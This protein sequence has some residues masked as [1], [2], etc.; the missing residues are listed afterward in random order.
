MDEDA[1]RQ[2]IEQRRVAWNAQDTK[3]YASLLTSDADIVSATGRAA[4][5]REEIIRLYVEQMSGPYRGAK[6]ASTVVTR[7]R[8]VRPDV[9]LVDTEFEMEGVHARDG[10]VMPLISGLTNFVLTKEDG[11]WLISSIRGMPRTPMQGPRQ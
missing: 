4:Y 3:T 2:V 5:G 7:I 10:A 9:A 11:G 8:F 6:V 1:I